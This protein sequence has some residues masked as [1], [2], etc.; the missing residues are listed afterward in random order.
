MCIL[1]NKSGSPASEFAVSLKLKHPEKANKPYWCVDS[2]GNSQ[3]QA[4]AAAATTVD[5]VTTVSCS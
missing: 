5:S 3:A 1:G 2:D 4:A